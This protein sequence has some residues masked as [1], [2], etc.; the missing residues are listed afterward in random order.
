MPQIRIS[1]PAAAF[2]ALAAALLAFGRP[3]ADATLGGP[4]AAPVTRQVATQEDAAA[5]TG[6]AYISTHLYF[7]TGRHGGQPPI[8]EEEFLQ[9]VAEV[10][11]PRFPSG[12]TLEEA[13]GQWRDKE[14]DINR[15]RS[16]ELTVLYPVTEAR[17]R[18]IDIE[19][20]RRA[21][22]LRY[23]L[24]SVGRADVKA[25]ADF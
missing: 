7:G 12:L 4:E 15:E 21:Y 20:I 8:P 17:K 2:L 10:I 18:D 23:G 5:Q 14:G 13:R 22:C 3:V 25:R 16:Y 6:S 24:E 1:T 9:F 19:Y 11:T